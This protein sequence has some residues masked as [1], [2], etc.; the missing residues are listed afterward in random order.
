[1]VVRP[2]STREQVRRFACARGLEVTLEQLPREDLDLAQG[3][4]TD[5][6]EDERLVVVVAGQR[7][8][9]DK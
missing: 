5:V 6:G 7:G 3:F 8:D 1:M 2:D 4:A 9:L